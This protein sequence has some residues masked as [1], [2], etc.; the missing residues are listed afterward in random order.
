MKDTDNGNVPL[1]DL[2][3]KNVHLDRKRTQSRSE[4]V[5]LAAD[6]GEDTPSLHGFVQRRPV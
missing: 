3:I 5:T 4:I 1:S 6:L 2:I